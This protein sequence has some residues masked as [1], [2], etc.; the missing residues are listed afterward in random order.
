MEKKLRTVA[1]LKE[2][3]EVP[4]QAQDARK[5]YT[6][7]RKT[8]LEALKG[9]EPKTIPQLAETT[10]LESSVVT[11]YLMTLLKFGEIEVDGIDD[12]DEYYLYKLKNA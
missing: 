7:M 2:K 5:K 12:S 3:R 9:S 4:Q 6:A 11:Y 1:L 10:G 8:L